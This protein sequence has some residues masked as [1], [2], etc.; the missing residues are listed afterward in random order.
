MP[1]AFDS[2]SP[3]LIRLFISVSI[4][5][6]L[7]IC[8]NEISFPCFTWD[9]NWSPIDF[10][11]LVGRK[12]S[13]I[14]L[15]AFHFFEIINFLIVF[16]VILFICQ[17]HQHL[18]DLGKGCMTNGFEIH[19]VCNRFVW[20]FLNSSNVFFK[21]NMTRHVTINSN[22]IKYY[23][24]LPTTE[25]IS[26]PHSLKSSMYVNIILTTFQQSTIFWSPIYF[27]SK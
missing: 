3:G 21:K 20:R 7:G 27:F 25:I 8:C 26:W 4:L 15:I 9:F 13:F 18:P 11:Y 24:C 12:P 1:R 17:H 5:D 6:R 23:L 16:S 2:V 19:P 14:F 22:N 10:F